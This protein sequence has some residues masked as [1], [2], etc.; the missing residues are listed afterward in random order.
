[1]SLL[2]DDDVVVDHDAERFGGDDD[3]DLLGHLDIGAGRGGIGIARGVVVHQNDGRGGELQ[4]PLHHLA[5]IGGRVVDSAASLH[6]VGDHLVALIQEQ[7]AE[8]QQARDF[9][10]LRH[11]LEKQ[12]SRGKYAQPS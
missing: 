2:A 4:R 1:V 6:L 10:G 3:D 9:I 12:S 8:L 11:K 7:D 5:D